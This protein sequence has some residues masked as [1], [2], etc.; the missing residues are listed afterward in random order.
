MLSFKYVVHAF[1][2]LQ[3]SDSFQYA[4]IKKKIGPVTL[5]VNNAGIV[6][7]KQI[8]DIQDE[9]I[10]KTLSVNAMAH[11]WVFPLFSWIMYMQ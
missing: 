7:G 5:L 1:Y 4:D 9:D 10:Q 8:V 11:I 6:H 2:S 3:I